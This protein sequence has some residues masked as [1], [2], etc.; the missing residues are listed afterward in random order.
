MIEARFWQ[1]PVLNRTSLHL[2][3][4]DAERFG[5]SSVPLFVGNGLLFPYAF[6]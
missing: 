5:A 1:Y 3:Q 4:G 6:W 2:L